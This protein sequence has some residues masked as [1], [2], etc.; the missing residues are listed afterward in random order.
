VAATIPAHFGQ[1]FESAGQ[2]LPEIAKAPTHRE[3]EILSEYHAAG[4]VS[5]AFMLRRGRWKLHHYAGFAPEL[6]DLVADPEEEVNL[7]EDPAHQTTL[8]Q[9]QA[10]LGTHLDPE[11]TSARAFADQA[12]MIARY[13]GREA[14]LK[15]GAPGAT[16]PPETT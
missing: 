1:T 9:M 12:A 8:A 2:P 6:F 14:A 16:P 4:A 13:G 11:A 7:A 15:L 3:R 10:A 5:G